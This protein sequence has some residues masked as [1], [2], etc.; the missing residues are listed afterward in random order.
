MPRLHDFMGK[1][2]ESEVE[3]KDAEEALIITPSTVEFLSAYDLSGVFVIE[4]W[5]ESDEDEIYLSVEQGG[6]K[7]KFRLSIAEDETIEFE[8]DEGY[9]EYFRKVAVEQE[10]HVQSAPKS[11]TS[12][13]RDF[14]SQGHSAQESRVMRKSECT[15]SQIC[16]ILKEAEDGLMPGLQ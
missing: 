9:M 10:E 15:E 11:A 5:M 13:S 3:E 1:W 7:F 8:P 2:I 16:S 6:E 12:I 14:A 4:G